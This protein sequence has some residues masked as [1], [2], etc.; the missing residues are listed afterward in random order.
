MFDQ[1]R[2]LVVDDDGQ[3]RALLKHALTQWGYQATAVSS[4]AEALDLLTSQLVDIALL[5]LRMPGMDGL[6][7]LRQIKRHDSTIAVVVMTGYP[8]VNSAVEALK[9]GAYDYLTKP[10]AMEH[11]RHLMS[12]VMERRLLRQEVSSLRS[13]LGGVLAAGELVA[14]SP[15]MVEVKQVVAQVAATDT[16]VLIEGESGTG[17]ELVAA[18]IHRLSAR[19]HGPFIPVNCSALPPDLVESELFGHERGAFTGAV[20]AH[21]G[22]FRAADGGTLFLDE[23]TELLPALQIKLLRV[24]Q[25]REIRPVGSTKTSTVDVRMVAATNRRLDEAVRD[26]SLREDLRYRLDVVRI[27][28]P[29]LRERKADIPALVAYFLRNLNERFNRQVTGI[30]P[31]ALAALMAYDF[32]GNVRHL[33]NLVERAY[34]LGVGDQLTLADLPNLESLGADVV[35][36]VLPLPKVLAEAEKGAI[37]SALIRFKNDKERA[38][39]ALGVSIRTFYRLLRKHRLG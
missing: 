39:Q 15:Q 21:Q 24:L 19:S 33:E 7:L 36:T 6:E 1:P 23:V 14:A 16:P 13:R 9:E 5:D 3:I 22:L 10:M 34:A 2:V 8:A 11:L 4:G 20:A 25:D 38:A 12:R 28:I 32:P 30:T 27:V 26:G 18:A 37:R 31:E 29:P 35:D 17:K